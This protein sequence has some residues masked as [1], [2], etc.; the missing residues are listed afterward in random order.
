ML[1]SDKDG[2][3]SADKIDISKLESHI[4]E[5]FSPLLCEME[6]LGQSLNFEEF[7]E[8]SERLL[9]TLSIDEKDK[10]FKMQK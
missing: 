10:I 6:E 3:I 5:A 7:Y 9:L 2:E 4:L 1:D 8:A